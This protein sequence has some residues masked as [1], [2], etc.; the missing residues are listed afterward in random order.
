M[1]SVFKKEALA[2]HRRRYPHVW[3]WHPLLG[4]KLIGN[5]SMHS[6]GVELLGP[7][8]EWSTLL[9]DC[10]A[11]DLQFLPGLID[12]CNPRRLLTAK[13][14]LL[15]DDLAMLV[16]HKVTLGEPGLGLADLA[17]ECMTLGEP[18]RDWLL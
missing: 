5:R 6:L 3:S 1:P 10:E 9:D 4:F 13:A 15:A 16:L 18:C 14:V 7:L 11:L 17:K 8:V 12:C 2:L